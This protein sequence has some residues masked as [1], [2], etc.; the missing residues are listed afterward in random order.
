MNNGGR[1]GS[2]ERHDGTYHGAHMGIGGDLSGSVA[3]T[4]MDQ[5]VTSLTIRLDFWDFCKPGGEG[6]GELSS[7]GRGVLG[8][9]VFGLEALIVISFYNF[10]NKS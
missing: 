8:K 10:I 6:F 1:G 3:D 4:G 7:L 2:A 9:Q 5:P